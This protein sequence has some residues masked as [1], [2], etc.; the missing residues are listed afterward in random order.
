MRKNSVKGWVRAAL[1]VRTVVSSLGIVN[2]K[3]SGHCPHWAVCSLSIAI[4][5][6]WLFLT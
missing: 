4:P 6:A 3:P 2:G 5:P 1:C